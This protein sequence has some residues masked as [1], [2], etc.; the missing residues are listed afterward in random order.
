MCVAAILTVH[1][2]S[3]LNRPFHS[4]SFTSLSQPIPLHLQNPTLR[5]MLSLSK[6]KKSIPLDEIP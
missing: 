6:R 5:S 4:T 2:L 3:L 1:T